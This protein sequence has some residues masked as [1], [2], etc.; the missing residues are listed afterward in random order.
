MYFLY[1][2]DEILRFVNSDRE[3]CL[4]SAELF[5]LNSTS[6]L[7]TRFLKSMDEKNNIILDLNLVKNNN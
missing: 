7:F 1:D 2:K 4:D 5:N 3:A 6:F